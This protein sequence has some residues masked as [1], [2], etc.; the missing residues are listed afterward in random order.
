M[1]SALQ[2][3]NLTVGH[4]GWEG[5]DPLELA[6]KFYGDILGL[7]VDPVPDTMVGKLRWFRIGDTSQQI[8]ISLEPVPD[9]L[10]LRPQTRGHP[11]FVLPYTTL[12]ALRTKL[13]EF[14]SSGHPGACSAPSLEGAGF[15]AG[16]EGEEVDGA[17]KGDRFFV[18]DFVGNR[19]EFAGI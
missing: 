18:R 1:I 10:V 17:K 13:A 5:Q 11:C 4:Q 9:T 6:D 16:R 3:V 2:H 8:H 7:K 19:L 14:A 15:V 12:T